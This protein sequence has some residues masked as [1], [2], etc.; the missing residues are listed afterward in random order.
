VKITGLTVRIL[1]PR[2]NHHQEVPEYITMPTR[3]N[4]IAIIHT[5]EGIDGV[6]STQGAYLRQLGRLWEAAKEHIHGRD[7]L[8]R[9][10]IDKVLR[11]RYYW[12]QHILGVLDYGLWDIAGKYFNAPVYKLLGATREKILA[13]GSTIHHSTD[14]RF[15][16]TVLECKA[17]GFKAIKLHPYCAAKDDVRL[18]YAVR[19]AVGDDYTLMID[20][21][22]YPAPY[23]RQEALMVG[24]VLDELS[25]WWYEDPLPK[26]DLDGLAEVTRECKVVQVRAADRVDTIAE[27]VPMLRMHCMDIMAVPHCFGI[28]DAMKLAHMAEAHNMKCEPHDFGGGTASLHIGLAIHNCDYYEQAVP[29]GCFDEEIYPGVYQDPIKVDSEGYVHAPAKPG[30][31]FGIDLKE[32]DKVTAERIKV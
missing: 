5:D 7:P 26:T 21:L 2:V 3:Q 9:G 16:D 20:T 27:Y 29:E 14:Q 25:F 6:I 18:C 13:Y 31:G 28:T 19:K 22:I 1:E 23:T 15:V 32:A 24:R 10:K 4:G 30:L 17:K 11:G 12:P 8:D